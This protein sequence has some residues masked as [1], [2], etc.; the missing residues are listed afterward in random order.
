MKLNLVRKKLKWKYEAFE[1]PEKILKTWSEI[2][3]KGK[4]E[5]IKWENKI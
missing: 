4:K 3:N 2:G 5:E 1:I